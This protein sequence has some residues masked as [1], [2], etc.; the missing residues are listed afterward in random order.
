MQ[1]PDYLLENGTKITKTGLWVSQGGLTYKDHT[2]VDGGPKL[3]V[4]EPQE[5]R[6]WVDHNGTVHTEQLETYN[7][8]EAFSHWLVSIKQGDY[9]TGPDGA[10]YRA[11]GAYVFARVPDGMCVAHD[12]YGKA[13]INQFTP[14]PTPP[15]LAPKVGHKYLLASQRVVTIAS[16]AKTVVTDTDG[17][18]Y[19]LHGRPLDVTVADLLGATECQWVVRYGHPEIVANTLIGDLALTAEVDIFGWLMQQQNRV[20]IARTPFGQS[21]PSIRRQDSSPYVMDGCDLIDLNLSKPARTIHPVTDVAL[22]NWLKR[23]I[24]AVLRGESHKRLLEDEWFARFPRAWKL[25]EALQQVK[26]AMN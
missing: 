24:S 13:S 16:V 23:E 14:A 4:R 17:N 2:P 22:F 6:H 10:T 8:R 3:A 7:Q 19:D 25:I 26:S 15:M 20:A 1:Q 12:G 5:G 9:L 21:F 18:S 11:I